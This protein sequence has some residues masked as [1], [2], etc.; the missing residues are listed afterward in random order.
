MA[1]KINI[2]ATQYY[3]EYY[4]RLKNIAL[5]TYEWELPETC[6][7]RFLEKTLFGLGVACFVDDPTMSYLNMKVT[8]S[9]TLNPYE[10]PIGYRAYSLG[11]EQYY[12][13]D[14]IVIV[15]NNRMMKS[16]DSSIMLY[17]EQLA[18][19]E[20]TRIVN[21]NAQKTPLLIRCDPK[22]EQ[23]LR[24]LYD[25]FQGDKPAIF[26]T[27][28]M[29]EKPIEVL[30]TGAPFLVDKFREE[31]RAVWNEALEFLGYNTNPSDKKK[32]RLI[33]NEV[34]ANN[35]QI[36]IQAQ[37]GLECRQEACDEFYKKFGVNISVK[38]RVHRLNDAMEEGVIDGEIYG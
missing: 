14:Q 17:A 34:D 21:L 24:A 16:T 18:M 31:K 27:K 7:Q 12:N 36:D 3:H 30:I 23:S 37:T 29:T 28:S 26:S 1:K 6:N 38:R 32:E 2:R 35:E 13:E 11:Y 10:E 25:Q 9:D 15:R 33:T 5:S 22:T 4:S 19:L 8:P 20:M